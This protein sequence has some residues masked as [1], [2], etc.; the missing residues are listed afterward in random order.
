MF[1]GAA[2]SLVSTGR[3]LGGR[4]P[5]EQL[6]GQHMQRVSRASWQ[7]RVGAVTSPGELLGTSPALQQ[8]LSPWC[9][10]CSPRS[11]HDERRNS[12]EGRQ[13]IVEFNILTMGL[14]FVSL[15][16]KHFFSSLLSQTH[17]QQAE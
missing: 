5:M 1:P 14:T 15:I 17:F 7:R 10:A 16:L 3:W 4:W 13:I 2:A 11:R 9:C 6:P 8:V 12:A